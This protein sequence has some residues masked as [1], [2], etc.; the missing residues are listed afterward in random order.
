MDTTALADLFAPEGPFLTVYLDSTSA[1]PQAAQALDLRWKNL[2]GDLAEQGADEKTLAAVDAAVDGD[3]AGGDTLVIVAAGGTVLFKRHLPEPPKADAGWWSPLPRVGPV[4]EWNQSAIPHVVVLADRTGAD[5]WVVD[6]GE[7]VDQIEVEGSADRDRLTKVHAGGWSYRRYDQRVMNGWDT[8]AGEVAAEVAKLAE[9]TGARLVA[10]A[11]DAQAVHYLQENLPGEVNEILQVIQHGARTPDGS[12]DQIADA[13]ITQV[14]DLA[15]RDTV[16]LL[17]TYKE[18]RGQGD[19]AAEGP[20]RTLEALARAQ[21]E[22][23]L[24][25]DDPGDD[26]TA[27]FGPEAT[28]VGTD[29]ATVEAMGAGDVREGRLVDVAIRAAL[30]TGADIRIVP[31]TTAKDGLGAVLRYTLTPA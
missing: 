22:T 1:E 6:D 30:G 17:G 24:V 31:S 23:L 9:H 10:V 8:N 4:L 25:H 7:V 13:V 3:H 27:W 20:A 19:R 29:R 16:G 11:G 14:A 5:I 26:R 21:V 2:R 28:H 15:A 18:E 12:I